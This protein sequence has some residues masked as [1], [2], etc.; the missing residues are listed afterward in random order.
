MRWSSRRWT[1]PLTA[2]RLG[3]SDKPILVGPWRGEVGFEVLYWIP[4]LHALRRRYG[5]DPERII[6]ITRGGMGELYQTPAYLELFAMRSPADLRVEN[7][8]QH[9]RTGM[10]KQMERSAWDQQVIRD[11]AETLKL[12][13]YHVLDPAWMYHR[14]SPFWEG[15]RGLEWFRHQVD[16]TPLP[17]M[18]F[19][20]PTRA[21][22]SW[23]VSTLPEKFIC[24]K[25]YA[26][27]TFPANPLTATIARETIKQISASVPVILLNP[28]LFMDD[29][30]DFT[31]KESMPNVHTLSDLVTLTPE[32]HLAVQAQI[33]SRSMG[34]VGTY[35]GVAQM[36]LRLGKP[37][38]SL[39][40][41][42]GG[43]MWAHKHLSEVLGNAMGVPFQVHKV[44]DVPLMQ[45][46]LPK[47]I[48]QA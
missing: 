22:G 8:L 16:Y 42:W 6:P 11:A 14:L 29:H 20:G 24:V 9:K 5:I 25:F 31:L 19:D 1:Y 28:N 21:I 7:R 32:N 41:E 36:A 40:T 18:P 10:L 46:V 34:F 37:S 35:G 45:S 4:F 17:A 12:S 44:G 39:Y 15:Q 13:R 23:K 48:L 2:T 3:R 38:L 47:F 43:T 27:A 26:R 30:M 33:L